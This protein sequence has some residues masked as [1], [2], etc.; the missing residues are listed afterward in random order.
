MSPGVANAVEQFRAEAPV[1]EGRCRELQ[2]AIGKL[3]GRD[4]RS[5]LKARRC[6]AECRQSYKHIES[7][8]EYFFRSSSRIYN[9]APK[10]E[11]EEGG[12]EYQSPL[13]LQVIE[14]GLFEK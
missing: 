9:T 7:F 1:F 3:D 10:F 5:V 8:L 12:M 6:L 13:G 2:M 4:R 14:A 11:A